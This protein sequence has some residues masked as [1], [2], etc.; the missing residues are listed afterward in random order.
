MK[1]ISA[2]Y[3]RQSVWERFSQI[4]QHICSAYIFY[5]QGFQSNCLNKCCSESLCEWELYYLSRLF[6]KSTFFS[7]LTSNIHLPRILQLLPS[8]LWT[9]FT[10]IKMQNGF[11]YAYFY[12]LVYQIHLSPQINENY[13]NVKNYISTW[14]S[15]AFVELYETS[16]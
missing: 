12:I 16:L 2:K 7:R 5:S 10:D 4:T 8:G 14:F 6:M 11:Y 13:R 15:Y 9:I 1:V 3:Y